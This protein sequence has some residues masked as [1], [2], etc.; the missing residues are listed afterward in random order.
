MARF[1]LDTDVM[2]DVSRGN[3][4]VASFVDSLSDAVISNR[5][6]FAHLIE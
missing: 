2:I 5:T 1:L 3:D 4:A 6:A